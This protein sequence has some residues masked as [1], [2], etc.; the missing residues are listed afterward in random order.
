M[1]TRKIAIKKVLHKCVSEAL[2]SSW[3]FAEQLT[4]SESWTSEL[5]DTG[6]SGTRLLALLELKQRTLIP[7]TVFHHWTCFPNKPKKCQMSLW[8]WHVLIL[9]VT[10]PNSYILNLELFAQ[11]EEEMITFQSFMLLSFSPASWRLPH[12]EAS[13]RLPLLCHARRRGNYIDVSL[14]LFC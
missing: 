12:W 9:M 7:A 3:Y 2:N 13:S 6:F 14:L 10:S 4:G 5:R 8:W 1:R 11:E